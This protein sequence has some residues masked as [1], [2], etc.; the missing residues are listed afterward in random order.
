[1]KIT[2]S[3][4]KIFFFLF[5]LILQ[6]CVE[7]KIASPNKPEK[8]SISVKNTIPNANKAPVKIVNQGKL[9]LES[10]QYQKAIDTYNAECKKQPQNL[11]L[12]KEYAGGLDNIKSNA[13][14]ALE[15]RDFA[16]AGKMYYIL[17]INYAKF[18]EI[19]PRLAFDDVYLNT[20][21]TYC[22]KSLSVQGFEEYRKGELDKALILWESVLAIDPNN[23][24][25]IEAVKTAK[26]Q[27]KNLQEAK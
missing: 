14:K 19:V 24:S 6:S 26:L 7:H 15:K 16:Y 22:K 27:Q 10:G 3:K 9:Y 2:N 23:K 5:M 13:D 12:K 8:S 20:K 18:N 17:N 25:V 11:E 21:L 4:L 1:M